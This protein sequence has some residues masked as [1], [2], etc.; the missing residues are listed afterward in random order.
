MNKAKKLKFL[1]F[2]ILFLLALTISD[3]TVV[4][5]NQMKKN[6]TQIFGDTIL[7]T[8][9]IKDMDI[10]DKNTKELKFKI[11]EKLKKQLNGLG[12]FFSNI[13]SVNLVHD[14]FYNKN[15]YRVQLDDYT[16][17][18]NDKFEL[19]SIS[20]NDYKEDINKKSR[21]RRSIDYFEK[22]NNINQTKIIIKNI[23]QL[24]NISND[25]KVIQNEAF[26]DDMWIVIFEKTLTNNLTNP[27]ESI[28]VFINRNTGLIQN[29]KIFNEK[30]NTVKSKITSEEAIKISK[31]IIDK[32]GDSSNIKTTL[33]II[34]PNHY[35]A[36]GL[37][38]VDDCVK[39]AWSVYDENIKVYVDA[40]TGEILGG[41]ETKGSDHAK[42]FG[43]DSVAYSYNSS[44]LAEA[45][46]RRL[47]YV[48]EPTFTTSVNNLRQAV[49]SYLSKGASYGF[50]ITCHTT[51]SGSA[52]YG[53]QGGSH[54][55]QS[56]INGNFHLVFLDACS[57]AANKSWANAFNCD[58]P[59][60]G[61]LGWKRSVG[62]DPT[63]Q[64]CQYFWARVG[65]KPLYNLALD[66]A[67]S[68]PGR[69]TT[70]IVY[71]GDKSWYGW[72]Y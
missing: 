6:T 40:I 31:K 60:R 62:M 64:F 13:K 38:K 16:I 57:T 46:F 72:A 61:F 54:I 17:E 71:F 18:L 28:K 63:Y 42:A 2:P 43:H 37:D 67:A 55:Y 36:K 53:G 25:F 56:D 49:L 41:D 47:G 4:K 45:G 7:K 5:A 30:P 35:W 24:L 22:I 68:V 15:K 1:I 44:K 29:L 3:F 14:N 20:N 39:L 9:S 32:Y 10:I 69:G 11:D 12:V 58:R 51:N 59:S 21:K 33:K 66:A 26:D 34:K 48:V 50:Y 70:P 8:Y 23:K 52:L 19:E 27:Y 65:S